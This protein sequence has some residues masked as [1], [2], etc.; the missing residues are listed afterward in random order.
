[1]SEPPGWFK[2]SAACRIL[3][4][5]SICLALK[6]GEAQQ[7]TQRMHGKDHA[8]RSPVAKNHSTSVLSKPPQSAGA[9]HGVVERGPCDIDPLREGGSRT[10]GE[11]SK[12]G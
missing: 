3:V 9:G 12:G 11:V 2:K 6:H 4:K 8:G 10:G 1:M 7:T 5:N